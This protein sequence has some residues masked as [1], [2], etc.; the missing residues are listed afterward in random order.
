[1]SEAL[2]RA[3]APAELVVEER[4]DCVLRAWRDSLSPATRLAY[5]RDV[6]RF[7]RWSGA[8]S[9]SA[10]V[11]NLL[12]GGK[13]AAESRV[14]AWLAAMRG[15]IAP[16]TMQRRRA[17]LRSVVR[18][19]NGLGVVTWVL[20]APV[21]PS[22]RP[23]GLRDTRG[24]GL[25]A[26]RAMRKIA[27]SQDGTKAARDV[28]LL[29]LLYA[30]GL[31]RA[32]VCALDV[33]SF[34]PTERRLAIIGKGRREPD[35]LTLPPETAAELEAY[36][37]ARGAPVTGPLFLSEDRARKGSGRLTGSGLYCLVRSL[38]RRAGL[39]QPV[40]PHRLRH[41][42]IT[43]ALDGLRGDVRRVRQFSRHVKLE[44]LMTYDDRRRDQAGEVA[45]FLAAALGDARRG[46]AGRGHA[47]DAG[48][49]E[50]AGEPG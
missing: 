25:A 1:M 26:V 46:G 39:E 34:Q 16:A 36:L 48:D 3:V 32:E 2:A 43:D 17:A 50:P 27:A 35:W 21:P 44:T 47:H 11:E 24:P 7:A 28:A 31:R 41:S 19:A 38:G 49:P 20:T 13:L 5:G 9:A 23:H 6:E 40:S 10:A 30:L 37:A 15:V 42:A 29:G 18:M 33:Q 14:L 45:S 4:I 8:A 22:D 12:R